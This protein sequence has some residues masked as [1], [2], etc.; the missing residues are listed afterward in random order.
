MK[1]ILYF[2]FGVTVG[3]LAALMLAPKSGEELR[4]DIQQRANSDLQKLQ[5]S[6]EQG[7]AE[8]NKKL[9]QVQVQLK[10]N[11]EM[12][13]GLIEELNADDAPAAA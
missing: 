1:D 7:L 8:V 2:I 12:G 13:E 9:E 4:V 5:K 11:E 10:K 3:A 6:Y